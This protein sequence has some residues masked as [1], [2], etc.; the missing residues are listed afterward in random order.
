M[1]TPSSWRPLLGGTGWS[2]ACGGTDAFQSGG[3]LWHDWLTSIDLTRKSHHVL[4]VG[5]YRARIHCTDDAGAAGR[6][7]LA[8]EAFFAASPLLTS[9]ST[10]HGRDRLSWP[11]R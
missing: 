9:C 2:R 5:F 7:A 3:T 4:R 10:V 8:L 6:A 11:S 1:V